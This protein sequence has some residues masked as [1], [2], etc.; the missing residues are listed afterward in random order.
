M[1]HLIIRTANVSH[2][3]QHFTTYKKWNVRLMSEMVTAHNC[4][5]FVDDS[6]KNWY[7]RKIHFLENYVIPLAQRLSEALGVSCNE[8]LDFAVGNRMEWI[9]SGQM[10]VAHAVDGLK[11]QEK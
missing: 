5:I 2:A 11:L 6:T 9:L 3:M 1:L 7:E 10:I 4:G 8:F